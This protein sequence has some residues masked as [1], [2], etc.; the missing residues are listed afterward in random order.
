MLENLPADPA[1]IDKL[2]GIY[3]GTDEKKQQFEFFKRDDQL[4]LKDDT[5]TGGNPFYYTG[6]NTFRIYG[7]EVSVYFELQADGRTKATT[8]WTDSNGKK[9]QDI[10]VKEK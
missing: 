5:P 10:S 2:T 1:A 9:Q 8:S 4:W 7:D 6:N 3:T